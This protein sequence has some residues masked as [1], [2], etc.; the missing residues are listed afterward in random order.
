MTKPGQVTTLQLSPQQKQ[1]LITFLLTLTDVS[2]VSDT[3]LS[4]PIQ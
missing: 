3:A 1:D 2:F 4:D